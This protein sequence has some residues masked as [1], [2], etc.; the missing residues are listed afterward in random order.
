MRGRWRTGGGGAVGA[1]LVLSVLTALRGEKEV[2]GGRWMHLKW[3][4]GW[5][6]IGMGG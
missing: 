3:D 2:E 4:G 1:D 6:R 5:G